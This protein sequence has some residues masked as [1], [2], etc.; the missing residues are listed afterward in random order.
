M[1]GLG[2]DEINIST[3][4]FVFRYM[5]L[6]PPLWPPNWS[7]PMHKYRK[8]NTV[9][10]KLLVY[11]N[12]ILNVCCMLWTP[13]NYTPPGFG[14]QKTK[15]M[16]GCICNKTHHHRDAAHPRG[17]RRRCTLCVLLHIWKVVYTNHL[18]FAQTR[19]WCMVS[20]YV[21][22][23]YLVSIRLCIL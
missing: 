2:T 17:A 21:V 11:M 6:E 3:Q 8:W 9:A 14:P 7:P 5:L 13:Y 23:C 12:G 19:W 20:P 18:L 1:Q 15:K 22:N 10:N 4:M 16:A